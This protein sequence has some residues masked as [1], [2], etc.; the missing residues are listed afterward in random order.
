MDNGMLAAG[1]AE[2]RTPAGAGVAGVDA[3][4]GE[5]AAMRGFAVMFAD[6]VN[7]ALIRCR[8]AGNVSRPSRRVVT[9][10]VHGL[11]AIR[12]GRTM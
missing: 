9:S 6:T 8:A 5:E 2:L 3:S 11:T 4:G 1:R 7:S 10:A 12:P